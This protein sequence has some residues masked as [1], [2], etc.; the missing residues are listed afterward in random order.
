LTVYPGQLDEVDEAGGGVYMMN[1]SMENLPFEAYGIYKME[2]EYET[3][4]AAAVATAAAKVGAPAAAAVAANVETPQLDL[5]TAGVRLMPVFTPAVKGNL[6]M[7]YQMGDRGGR[8]VSGYMV[9]AAVTCAPT[10]IPLK[11]TCDAGLYLL[12][13]D[14]PKTS[15]DEGWNPLFARYPQYSELYVFWYPGGRWTDLVMPKIGASFVPMHN[16]KLS[17]MAA[18]LLSE[19]DNA[20]GETER[21]TLGV[22]K[23][24][25]TIKEGW[26]VANGTRKDKL[27][28]HLWVE[29]FE[30]GD[31]YAKDD[32]A[33]FARW[34]LLYE[35]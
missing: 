4:A 32:T 26:L 19:Q 20:A 10:D 18:Y 14:D 9:D 31:Y 21:G 1:K 34:Q 13:G 6:E 22:L 17:A 24:E 29:A 7:A 27:S 16:V 25:F 5:G 15:D 33:Y 8:D 23:S 28:G 12:S 3:R 2:E 11:P 35:Y 30:P